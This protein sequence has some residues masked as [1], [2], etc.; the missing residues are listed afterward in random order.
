MPNENT[1][2]AQQIAFTVDTEAAPNKKLG[3]YAQR[4]VVLGNVPRRKQVLTLSDRLTNF[5]EAYTPSRSPTVKDSKTEQTNQKSTRRYRSA[6]R[7]RSV[8]GGRSTKDQFLARRHDH[9]PG[10]AAE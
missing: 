10:N 7:R 9:S 5:W 1:A 4:I 8:A 3:E 2:T 6:K